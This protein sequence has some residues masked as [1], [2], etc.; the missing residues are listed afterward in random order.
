MADGLKAGRTDHQ[1][2][3]EFNTVPVESGCLTTFFLFGSVNVDCITIGNDYLQVRLLPLPP[4]RPES[5][6]QCF[7]YFFS[8]P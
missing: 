6:G 7:S 3:R 2:V 5:W 4:S 1:V 8:L